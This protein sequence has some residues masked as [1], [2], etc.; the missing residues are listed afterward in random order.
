M[1]RSAAI[2]REDL[3]EDLFHE[4]IH[5]LEGM[6]AQI[7]EAFIRTH[8]YCGS[9]DDVA[10]DLNLSRSEAQER[11]ELANRILYSRLDRKPL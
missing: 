1:P 11:V 6:P 10:Q 5:A 2:E 7:R 3:R 9:V 4:I 8:Y